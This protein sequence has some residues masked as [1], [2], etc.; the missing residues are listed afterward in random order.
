[1]FHFHQKGTSRTKEVTGQ[2]FIFLKRIHLGTIATTITVMAIAIKMYAERISVEPV[3]CAS[4]TWN[5]RPEKN[6][7][8][9]AWEK[10][11]VFSF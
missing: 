8:S 9:K 5:G 6:R 4:K 2:N 3:D 1:L 11:R 10:I 7:T